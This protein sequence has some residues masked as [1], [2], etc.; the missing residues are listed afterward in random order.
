MANKSAEPLKVAYIAGCSYSGTTLLGFLLGSHPRVFFAGE[1]NQFNRAVPPETLRPQRRVCTCGLPYDECPVWAR[2]RQRAPGKTD[3]NP[4]PGLSPGNL[5]LAAR[6]ASGLPLPQPPPYGSPYAELLHAIRDTAM[7]RTPNLAWVVDS[8]KTLSG[9]AALSAEGRI[10]LR[11]LYVVRDGRGV[12]ASYGRRGLGRG[13]GAG[14]WAVAN[15]SLPAFCRRRSLPVLRVEYD[16][17]CTD[18]AA[19]LARVGGFLDLALDAGE[20][21]AGVAGTEYHTYGGNGGV[22]ER[23]PIFEGIRHRPPTVSGWGERVLAALLLNPLNR[24]LGIGSRSS[25]R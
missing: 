23:I 24:A 17:L 4:A 21:A 8:S 10:D 12:V 22:R 1:V 3:L 6:T 25:G 9:L 15:L 11:V 14:A 5:A 7:E 2:V 19:E 18:P 20:V 13:Y 16:R